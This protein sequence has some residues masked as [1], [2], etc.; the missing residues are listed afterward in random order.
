MARRIIV[1]QPVYQANLR[2]PAQNLSEVHDR[3]PFRHF[4][5]NDFEMPQSTPGFGRDVRL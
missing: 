3:S 1:S 5:R 4:N 2:A